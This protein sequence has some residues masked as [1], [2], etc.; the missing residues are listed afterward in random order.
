[1]DPTAGSE[2]TQNSNDDIRDLIFPNR[3]IPNSGCFEHAIQPSVDLLAGNMARSIMAS[4]PNGW[5]IS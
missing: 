4:S 3:A 2:D 5:K 1:M